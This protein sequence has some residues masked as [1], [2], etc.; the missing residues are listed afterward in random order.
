MQSAVIRKEGV[1][2]IIRK[3]DEENIE[4]TLSTKCDYP[5]PSV[6]MERVSRS[7]CIT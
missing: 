2:L 4:L 5:H 1:P 7:T 3:I 6:T